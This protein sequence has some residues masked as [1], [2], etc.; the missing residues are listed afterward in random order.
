MPAKLKTATIALLT[1][2]FTDCVRLCE[3]L[4][5]S[6]HA[7]EVLHSNTLRSC[8]VQTRSGEKGIYVVHQCGLKDPGLVNECSQS[9]ES[10]CTARFRV[11]AITMRV[12]RPVNKPISLLFE[13]IEP[14]E[15]W[16]RN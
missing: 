6:T 12:L 11:E 8:H 5:T 4:D 2:S 13:R 16:L 10:L 3:K 7:P 9:G 14:I 15:K 1:K